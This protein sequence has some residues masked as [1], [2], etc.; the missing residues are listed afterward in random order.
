[1]ENMS[2]DDDLERIGREEDLEKMSYEDF[3]DIVW[4]KVSEKVV[5]DN[6]L[7]NNKDLVREITF[8]LYRLYDKSNSLTLH[9]VSKILESVF[10]SF[11]KYG[12]NCDEESGNSFNAYDYFYD[13]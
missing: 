3:Y 8:D 2:Y 9:I 13:N 1:M 12:N 5:S 6:Y 10:Y 7:D 4:E 11:Q